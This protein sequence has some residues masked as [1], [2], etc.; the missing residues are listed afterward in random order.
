[1]TDPVSKQQFSCDAGAC[2]ILDRLREADHDAYL[3]GGCVRDLLMGCIPKDWDV[4]TSATPDEVEEL[5]PRTVAV[6]KAFGVMIVMTDRGDY[7][8]ATFRGEGDYSDGRRPDT[9]R[10]TDAREDVLRRDFTINALLYDPDAGVVLDFVGGQRDLQDGVI[11][12]VGAPEERFR[13]DHLRLLRAV[14]FAART[15]FRIEA[16]TMVA[17]RELAPLVVSVS[18]ERVGDELT[19]MFSEGSAQRAF[20]LLDE[21]GLLAQVLPEVWRMHGVEQPPQFHPEGDVWTHTHLMLGLL[22]DT[23]RQSEALGGDEIRTMGEG[24][25]ARLLFGAPAHRGTLA[26]AVV[27]H[28][29]GKPATMTISDR[30]RFHGHDQEGTMLTERILRRLRRSGREIDAVCDLVARH[31]K[32]S[33]ITQMREAKRRRFLM[34]PSFPLHLELHR[35]DCLG[36]HGKLDH[37]AFSFDHWQEELRRPPAEKPLLTGR[38]LMGVGYAPGPE[39]GRVLE[40]VQDA[41]LEG[42]VSTAEEALA[43]AQ[44]H[45]PV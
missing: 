10:F 14:R 35:I 25:S 27:L 1:M 19:R 7:E 15:G 28:D 11:R 43:W 30:I 8:V 2:A 38:D 33:H 22:D 5:F 40:A 17:M 9:V 20:E 32:F 39:M 6:G 18:G 4:A 21:S 36:S 16:D 37:L 29:V 26:W 31:M 3:V 34:E 23:V 24:E 42:E 45:W 13:E 44:S 12:T 41:R